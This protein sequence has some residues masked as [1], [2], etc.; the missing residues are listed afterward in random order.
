[1]TSA[2]YALVPSGS[3]G[4]STFADMPMYVAPNAMN[5]IDSA[6]H[7]VPFFAILG[8]FAANER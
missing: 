6:A 4:I 5:T 1:M 2:A 8:L 3:S 7:R